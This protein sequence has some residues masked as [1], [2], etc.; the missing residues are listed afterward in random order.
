VSPSTSSHRMVFVRAFKN[1][2]SGKRS[3]FEER[4]RT[5]A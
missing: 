4:R 1:A 5:A 3:R 2:S